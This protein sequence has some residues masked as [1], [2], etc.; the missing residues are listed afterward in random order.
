MLQALRIE[1]RSVRMRWRFLDIHVMD[2]SVAE[3]G[4]Y[5]SETWSRPLMVERPS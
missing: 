4:I 2:E 3:S 5:R 1:S